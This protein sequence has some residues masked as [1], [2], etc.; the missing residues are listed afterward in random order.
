MA[1]AKDE[2]DLEQ[3][4]ALAADLASSGA[5]LVVQDSKFRE[6]KSS[7]PISNSC[8]GR[9]ENQLGVVEGAYKQRFYEKLNMYG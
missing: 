2:M 6:R 8:K 1:F 7:S 9:E 3:H 5:A 4:C